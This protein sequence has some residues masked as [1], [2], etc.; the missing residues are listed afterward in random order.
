MLILVTLVLHQCVPC[1]QPF[2][3]VSD[4]TSGAAGWQ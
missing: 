2:L 4:A 3:F 1:L